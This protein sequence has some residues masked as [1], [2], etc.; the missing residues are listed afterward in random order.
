MATGG[1]CVCESVYFGSGVNKAAIGLARLLLDRLSIISWGEGERRRRR[2]TEIYLPPA[3]G[4]YCKLCWV[5]TTG[6]CCWHCTMY[7]Y[8]CKNT[9]IH[10]SVLSICQQDEQ[11]V[12]A[13]VVFCCEWLLQDRMDE[14]LERRAIHTCSYLHSKNNLFPT[15]ISQYD[16]FSPCSS[17]IN[18]KHRGS[19]LSLV[20]CVSVHTCLDFLSKNLCVQEHACTDT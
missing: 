14:V 4:N 6:T 8:T 10:D 19:I 13:N 2:D 12:K 5:H 1:L 9:A 17:A 7:M 16:I 15:N 18:Q 11:S 20:E 3:P